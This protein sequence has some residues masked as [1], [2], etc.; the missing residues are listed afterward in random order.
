MFTEWKKLT[1]VHNLV[2]TVKTYYL[3]QSFW[4]VFTALKKRTF[5][6]RLHKDYICVGDFMVQFIKIILLDKRILAYEAKPP[7]KL[8][9]I[10][11]I[12]T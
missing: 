10:L 2:M 5:F 12:L 3:R 1:T 6:S 4:Y 9:T 8:V 7:P 11:N